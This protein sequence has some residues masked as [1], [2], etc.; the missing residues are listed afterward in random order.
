MKY[1]V[2]V[3]QMAIFYY[4]ICLIVPEAGDLKS[5]K[6]CNERITWQKVKG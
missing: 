5:M 4:I 1:T 3:F 2:H 6:A